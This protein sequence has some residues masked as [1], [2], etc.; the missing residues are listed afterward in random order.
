MDNGH[1]IMHDSHD[2]SLIN[3]NPSDR[4]INTEREGQ[5]KKDRQTE[6]NK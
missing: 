4:A 3:N 2:K 1:C 6:R 5:K